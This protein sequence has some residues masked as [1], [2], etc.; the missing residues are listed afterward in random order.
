MGL[1]GGWFTLVWGAEGDAPHGNGRHNL[2]DLPQ[3]PPGAP[4]GCPQGSEG[5]FGGT[6]GKAF[7]QKK[8]EKRTQSLIRN[9]SN[10]AEQADR[11]LKAL[12]APLPASSLPPAL[13]FTASRPSGNFA[14]PSGGRSS[15]A[16]R[17]GGAVPGGRAVA[18]PQ[19]RAEALPVAAPGE[20]SARRSP[21]RL[22]CLFLPAKRKT[23]W[24]FFFLV[25]RGGGSM[26][27]WCFRA[28]CVLPWKKQLW[29]PPPSLL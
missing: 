25:F 1:V 27:E 9:L 14:A 26:G 4:H 17:P 15:P 11:H 5:A 22:V 21:L 12:G 16:A 2:A 23:V 8:K 6:P 28:L 10:T 20:D 18:L 19:S 7:T 24:F 29:L 3:G 13:P